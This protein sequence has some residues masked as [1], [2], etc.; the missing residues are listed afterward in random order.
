MTKQARFV[1]IWTWVGLIL[2]VY[3]TLIGATGVYFAATKLPETVLGHT[4]P[5][6][7][8]GIFMLVSGIVFFLIG[9][10]AK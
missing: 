3:G 10:R 5:N 8:W 6:L 4:N 7:W 1:S 2:V 9:R